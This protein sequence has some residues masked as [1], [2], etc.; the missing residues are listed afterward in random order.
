[1]MT[2]VTNKSSANRE[3]FEQA[4]AAI[5]IAEADEWL[6]PLRENAI[7]V[8]SQAGFP[9]TRDEDWKYTS[10]SDVEARSATYLNAAQSAPDINSI[11]EILGGLAIDPGSFTAVFAN[12]LFCDRLS[13]LPKKHAGVTIDTLGRLGDQSKDLVRRQLGKFAQIECSQLAAL[14][15]AFLT[16]GL[17]IRLPANSDISAQIHVI[18]ISDEQDISV[19]P[20]VLIS[21]GEHS[22]ASVIEHYVGQGA[23]CT[24]AVTEIH[25]ADGA[26]LRYSKIQQEDARA[27]HLAAQYVQLEKDSRFDAVHV[28]LGA[29]LAR[30]DLT[31]RLA[32]PG[33]STQLDGLFVVDGERHVDNHTRL[34]HLEPRTTSVENYRGIITDRGRGVFNG[35]II[36]H[37][38]ADKSDAQLNNRNLVLSAEAEIDTKPELEIYTDDVKCAHGTTTGQLDTNAMFY[39]RVRGIPEGQAK[40]MLMAAFANEIINRIDSTSAVLS[41][42]IRNRMMRLLPG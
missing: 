2:T 26:H 25:C 33:A 13:H 35:K 21:L 30:N 4:F 1:M 34:D 8:F 3:S 29:R 23:S 28:D 11:E 10:L 6:Q 5:R 31:V 36:V 40:Q 18:F 41:D 38:G 14:N 22:R 32:G 9:T 7:Q 17:F 37:A 39:L 24:N 27:Y 20:R 16:D 19:Q 42:H 12:G 15:T